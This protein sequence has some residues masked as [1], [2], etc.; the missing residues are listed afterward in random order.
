MASTFTKMLSEVRPELETIVTTL[1]AKKTTLPQDQV[2]FQADDFVTA[3]ATAEEGLRQVKRLQSLHRFVKTDPATLDGLLSAI[4]S[5]QTD[6]PTTR[7]ITHQKSGWETPR[8][9]EYLYGVPADQILSFNDLAMDQ[10]DAATE[11]LIP[12]PSTSLTPMDNGLIFGPQT[13][14]LFCGTDVAP[15][16]HIGNDG[17]LVKLSP[18]DTVKQT[19]QNVMSSEY[20]DIPF[21]ETT[22]LDHYA[23][24]DYTTDVVQ[25]MLQYNVANLLAQ[26]TR[27]AEVLSITVTK[28]Q[29]A[30]LVSTKV[31]LQNSK[32]ITVTTPNGANT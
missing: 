31:R 10:F 27:I 7:V 8:S 14:D 16:L 26:D 22:G 25:Q 13:D 30:V 19:V 17:D 24:S 6:L 3:L 18:L 28:E 4:D 5:G 1:A 2:E 9:L 11:I 12:L 15:D 32:E 20:G 29:N 21:Y 23:G